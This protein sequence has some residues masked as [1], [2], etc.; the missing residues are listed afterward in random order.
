[1]ADR[2]D[3]ILRTVAQEAD[4]GVDYAALHDAILVAHK[5]KQRTL[6]RKSVV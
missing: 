2:M 1:M 6:D 4:R 3:E 5:K